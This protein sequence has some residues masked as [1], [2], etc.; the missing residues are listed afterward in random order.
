MLCAALLRHEGLPAAG[1]GPLGR[2]FITGMSG[3]FL[4]T[5]HPPDS[6]SFNCDEGS[7]TMDA[8]RPRDSRALDSRTGGGLGAAQAFATVAPALAAGSAAVWLGG[9][10]VVRSGEAI[11]GLDSQPDHQPAFRYRRDAEVVPVGMVL[12]P[13]RAKDLDE[14]FDGVI[15]GSQRH[16]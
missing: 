2:L 4:S 8:G 14:L 13:D 12:P 3:R 15:I 1:F 7:R 16:G 5:V 9:Y 6:R 10:G 11:S